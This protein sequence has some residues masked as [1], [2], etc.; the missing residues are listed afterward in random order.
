MTHSDMLFIPFG[1][2]HEMASAQAT[3]PQN[4]STTAEFSNFPC[5][6]PEN[7]LPLQA[8]LIF[9]DTMAK[10]IE[11]KVEDWAKG[12]FAPGS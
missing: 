9:D 3:M 7:S 2:T 5:I 8:N 6:T 12:F 11:E 1:D 4:T 10:S